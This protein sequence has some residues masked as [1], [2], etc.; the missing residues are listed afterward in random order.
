M[1]KKLYES[2]AIGKITEERFDT[3]LADYEMEQKTLQ[4]DV[5]AM[6]QQLAAF[7]ED[8]ARVEQ[9][10]AL[11]KKYTDFTEL[12]TP[13]INEFVD[14]I[15]VHAPEKIDGDRVQ[16]VEIF[17]KFIGKFELPAPELAPEEEK[18]QE[19]LKRHRIKSRER[20]R[21]VKAGERIPGQPV[22]CTCICCGKTFLAKRSGVMYCSHACQTKYYRQ[23][24]AAKRSRE[25]TC[26]NCGKVFVTTR[27]DVKYCSEEC[28]YENSQKLRHER[29]EAK[30]ALR[31]KAELQGTSSDQPKEKSA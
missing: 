10:L 14:K 3:L 18:R 31:A 11:A 16:E 21:K 29:Y 25:C 4:A 6:E 28:R 15:L 7:T 13:M 2:F 8:T 12:T 5:A 19:Q 23:Q 1:I 9:F 27:S 17:L 20:Y 22:E 26:E 24:A 30:K